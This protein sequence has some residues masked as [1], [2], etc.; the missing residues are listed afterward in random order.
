MKHRSVLSVVVP[1]ALLVVWQ[2]V[3]SKPGMQAMLPSPWLVVTAWHEWIF[4]EATGMGLNPYLGT[5]W[6]NVEYSGTRVIAGFVLSMVVAIPLG[7]MI[8]S[9]TPKLAG[10]QSLWECTVS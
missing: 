10:S 9:P 8:G 7:L 5:W 3:G 1:L 6:A 2:I 4:G